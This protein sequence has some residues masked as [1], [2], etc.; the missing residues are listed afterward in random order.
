[1]SKKV[2]RF[3]GGDRTSSG[4]GVRLLAASFPSYQLFRHRKVDLTETLLTLHSRPQKISPPNS[5][6]TT[7]QKG[8]RV[9]D[10]LLSL[11]VSSRPLFLHGMAFLKIRPGDEAGKEL[12]KGRRSGADSTGK[13]QS[14]KLHSSVVAL[15]LLRASTKQHHPR[16]AFKEEDLFS[17]EVSKEK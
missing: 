17:L 1:M 7:A 10:R 3:G 4:A 14:T 8:S 5:F 2:S 9:K 13:R 15:H 6:T 12:K 16:V 11:S